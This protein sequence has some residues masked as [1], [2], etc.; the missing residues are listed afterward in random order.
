M[1][2]E[3]NVHEAK[4]QLSRLLQRVSAGEEIVIA[5]RGVPVARLVPVREAKAHRELGIESG[6]LKV[7][8]DFDAPLSGLSHI[9]RKLRKQPVLPD[10]FRVLMRTAELSIVRDAQVSRDP[11]D[12]YLHPPLH[13]FGIADFKE[14]DRIVAIGY[15]H[16]CRRLHE[17]KITQQEIAGQASGS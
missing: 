17:W 2:K 9:V 11:A 7:A 10:I 14:I 13:D 16:A 3:V 5:N 4:T 15:D 8:D 6:H 1:K 12:L